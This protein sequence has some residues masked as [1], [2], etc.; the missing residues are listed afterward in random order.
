M[1]V[2]IPKVSNDCALAGAERRS[3]KFDAISDDLPDSSIWFKHRRGGLV[4][5]GLEGS[6][7]QKSDNNHSNGER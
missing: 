6:R 7:D 4:E 3:F 1:N 2:R 5:H